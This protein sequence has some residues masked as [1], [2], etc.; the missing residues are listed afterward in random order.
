N[1]YV[2]FLTKAER[3]TSDD[4]V[5]HLERFVRLG[6]QD[7]ICLGADFDGCDRLPDDLSG[8]SQMGSLYR[9]IAAEFSTKLA[10]AVFYR[11]AEQFIHKYIRNQ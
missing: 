1:L 11:S 5:R 6:A 3:A 8:L 2:P 10:D 9:R 7:H 4:I